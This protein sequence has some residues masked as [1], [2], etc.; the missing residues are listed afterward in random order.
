MV[1]ASFDFSDAEHVCVFVDGYVV[2]DADCVRFSLRGEDLLG[3]REG[4]QCEAVLQAV[5][6]FLSCEVPGVVECLAA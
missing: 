6:A 4:Q 1:E 3:R 5:Q 2:G